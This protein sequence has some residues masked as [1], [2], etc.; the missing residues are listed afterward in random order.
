MPAQVLPLVRVP[1]FTIR[2]R[3]DESADWSERVVRQPLRTNPRTAATSLGSPGVNK[4]AQQ[5]LVVLARPALASRITVRHPLENDW[6][7][8]PLAD[9][10]NHIGDSTMQRPSF[11]TVLC[12]SVIGCMT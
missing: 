5:D 9:R 2:T 7:S 12:L 4:P 11:F 10:K 6:C 1:R 8:V 3:T